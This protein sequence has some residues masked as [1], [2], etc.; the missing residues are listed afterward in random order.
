[1]DYTKWVQDAIINAKK[2]KSKINDEVL[3][4]KGLSST[5]NRHLLNNLCSF[6]E[7]V[8]L[9]IGSWKGSTIIASSFKNEGKFYAIDN[10]SQQFGRQSNRKE[11]PAVTLYANKEKFSNDAKFDF[12]ECDSWK[13]DK[14]QIKEKVNIYFY[15]GDHSSE[16][17][18]K[19]FTYYDDVL[20]DTFIMLM[21]DWNNKPIRKATK[22]ALKSYKII[23]EKE[24]FTPHGRNC[25]KGSW[26]NGLYIAVLTK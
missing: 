21:D 5:K 17:T 9:E 12:F 16:G 23:F 15:D 25:V 3:L 7:V 10:F 24:L 2:R 26:W 8:Y 6:P 22:K 11:S 14:S 4:I 18:E 1:M 13:F 19:A 20:A